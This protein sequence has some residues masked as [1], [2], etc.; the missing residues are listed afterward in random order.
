MH[1]REG[2]ARRK[3]SGIEPALLLAGASLWGVFGYPA[4]ATGAPQP[5]EVPV[6]LVT[7]STDGLGRE[8]ARRLAASGAHVIV[9]G[10]NAE[11]GEE[12]VREIAASGVGSARFYR[13]D[14]AS[15]DDVRELAQSVLRDYDRLDLLVNNAG[16]WLEGGRVLSQDGHE[17]HFQVNYLAGFLLTRS[18]LPLLRSSAPSRIVN[19]ASLAQNPMDFNNLMLEQGYTDGRAYGQSKLA[20]ILM[21]VD[22]AEELDGSGV[23]IAALHPATY[24][25][26]NMVLERGID[27]ITSVEQGADA[28]MNVIGSPTV[29]N[30]SFFNGLNRANPN[31]QARDSEARARL[32]A[33]SEELS[34]L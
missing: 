27:P 1:R 30:G 32:R 12:L 7:G 28:V 23:T 15:L 3:S 10:R 8:V 34:G 24:M 14:F 9:H 11:R 16:I 20:Q 19:V 31:A 5:P 26:T 18:L 2:V 6:V 13:A 33:M 22:M 29:E 21:T 17:M 4:T 25:G